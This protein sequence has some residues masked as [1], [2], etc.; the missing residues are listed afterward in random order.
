M[1]QY[2]NNFCY[3]NVISNMLHQ[4]NLYYIMLHYVNI[5]SL[6]PM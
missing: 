1:L 4:Y 3:V 5:I 6:M 2:I